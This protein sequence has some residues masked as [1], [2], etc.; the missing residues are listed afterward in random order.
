[1]ELDEFSEEYSRVFRNNLYIQSPGKGRIDRITGVRVEVGIPM[2]IMINHNTPL[3]ITSES[4]LEYLGDD[5][6]KAYVLE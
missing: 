6:G 4:M 3:E 2:G 5:T 1:M